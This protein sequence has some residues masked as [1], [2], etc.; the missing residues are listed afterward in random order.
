MELLRWELTF[1]ARAATIAKAAA[2]RGDDVPESC[3]PPE[4]SNPDLGV[5]LEAPHGH[6]WRLSTCRGIGFGALGP[7][8]WTAVDSYAQTY[9]FAQ[10]EVDY[11]DFVF[12]IGQ[13]DEEFLRVSRKQAAAAADRGGRGGASGRGAATTPRR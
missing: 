3:L 4:L 13:L 10:N 1:G 7:I 2:E 5:Y 6:F 12:I 8:P 9:G 11:D